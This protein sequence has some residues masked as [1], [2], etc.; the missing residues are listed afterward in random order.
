MLQKRL[1]A[2]VLVFSFGSLKKATGGFKNLHSEKLHDLC[3]PPNIGIKSRM[4]VLAV[5]RHPN[6]QRKYCINKTVK[7]KVHLTHHC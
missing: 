3:L 5:Y 4:C 1:G 7:T 6:K 2:L